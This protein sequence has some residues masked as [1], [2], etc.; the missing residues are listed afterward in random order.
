M[1][2]HGFSRP[3]DLSRSVKRVETG[4]WGLRDEGRVYRKGIYKGLYLV[5]TPTLLSRVTLST[6]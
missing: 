6:S 5:P 4:R 1:G 2:P 3:L